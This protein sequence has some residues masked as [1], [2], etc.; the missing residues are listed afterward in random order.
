MFECLAGPPF[1]DQKSDG[2][3]LN[4]VQ[5]SVVDDDDDDDDDNGDSLSLHLWLRLKRIYK[6]E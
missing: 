3:P 1:V 6:V 4:F 2:L 5:T